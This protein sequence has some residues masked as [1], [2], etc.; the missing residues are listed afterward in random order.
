MRIRAGCVVYVAVCIQNYGLAWVFAKRGLRRASNVLPRRVSRKAGAARG[1]SIHLARH[2]R[3]ADCVRGCIHVG[4]CLRR[5]GRNE[6][7]SLGLS[8]SRPACLYEGRS[9]NATTSCSIW[10]PNP[11]GVGELECGRTW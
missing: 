2:V 5:G 8:D 10:V 6:F 4:V 1:T 11:V 9:R 3:M 7:G